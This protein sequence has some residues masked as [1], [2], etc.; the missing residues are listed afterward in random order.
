MD[1]DKTVQLY[2]E[3]GQKKK[4]EETAD[5]NR[6]NKEQKWYEKVKSKRT[7]EYYQAEYLI[8]KDMLSSKWTPP[9]VDGEGK[10]LKYP[11]KHVNGIYMV[12]IADGTE[13]IKSRQEWVA[14]DSDGNPVN[15]SMDNKEMYDDIRP[16]YTSKPKTRERD[17]EMILEITSIE[18]K[19]KYTLPFS[20]D[21]VQKLY[22][23]RNGNC[24]LVLRD[25]SRDRPPY[26]IPSLEH[27]KTRKFDELWDWASTPRTKLDRSYGDNLDG[28]HIG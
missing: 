15:L 26:E 7:G 9:H 17:A 12:R 23:M 13:W 6:Y 5:F 14:L 19:I 10:P 11:L 2:E 18:Y 20:S 21:N 8:Q 3:I 22:D 25:E 4:F 24:S 28:S 1:Y 16:V 27:F